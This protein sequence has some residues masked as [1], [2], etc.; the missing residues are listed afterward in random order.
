MRICAFLFSFI[1]I[2]PKGLGSRSEGPCAS[3]HYGCW[4]AVLYASKWPVTNAW[5]LLKRPKSNT[6][7]MAKDCPFALRCG[8][9]KCT[10]AFVYL[11]A[12]AAAPF[13]CSRDEDREHH[14]ARRE[15]MRA[16]HGCR[17]GRLHDDRWSCRNGLELGLKGFEGSQNEAYSRRWP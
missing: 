16:D 12:A 2:R 13:C 8:S 6:F 1:S 9:S 15:E 11:D 7:P 3:H 4:A 10:L 17:V 5:R 14:C